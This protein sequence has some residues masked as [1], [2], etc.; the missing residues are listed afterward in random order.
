[1]AGAAARLTS[2]AATQ[3]KIDYNAAIVVDVAVQPSEKSAKGE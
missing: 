3:G 1:M 2:S